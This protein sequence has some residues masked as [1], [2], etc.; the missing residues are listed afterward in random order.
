MIVIYSYNISIDG[1]GYMEIYDQTYF[2]NNRD[3]EKFKKE[4]PDICII[5]IIEP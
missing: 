4:N 3:F 1:D 2:T 5:D